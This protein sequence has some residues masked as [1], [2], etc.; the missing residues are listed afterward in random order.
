MISVLRFALVCTACVLFC[1]GAQ[2]QITA[3]DVWADWKAYVTSFGYSVSGQETPTSGGLTVTGVSMASTGDASL[4]AA[5]VFMDQI[6]LTNNADGSVSIDLPAVMPIEMTAPN[7]VGGSTRISMDY[8]H[9][10]I[11]ILAAGTPE[12]LNYNYSAA[13]VTLVSTGY[14]VDGQLLSADTNRILIEFGPLTGMTSMTLDSQRRYDQTVQVDSIR[15]DLRAEDVSSGASSAIT[16]QTQSVTF[17]GASTVPLRPIDPSDMDAMFAAGFSADGTFA[18]SANALDVT[19][20]G[21]SGASQG[22]VLSGEGTLGVS[23]GQD[24]LTY[25]AV[26]NDV[27]VELNSDQ[28]PVPLSLGVAESRFN[29]ATP[30]GPSD[31]ADDFALGFRLDGFSISDAIWNMI[32]PSGQVPR[33]P[34]LLALDLTGKARLL[35]DLFDPA[36][37]TLADEAIGVPAELERLDVNDLQFSAGGAKLT[38]SGGFDFETPD[39]G[40]PMPKGAIDLKLTGA[41]ALI[42]KLVESGLLPQDQAVGARLMMGLLAVPGQ[43]PDTLTSRIEI[44]DEGHVLANGQRIR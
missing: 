32:D 38:G 42:D 13:S 19:A 11:E 29:L 40:L 12:N 9:N 41:N 43:G 27:K 39:G 23:M 18:Y 15:Y 31:M 17:E 6:V 33:D 20:K 34:A 35:F 7:E 44:N 36:S 2:A 25:D 1:S 8:R 26:Q 24:G 16:G 37:A 4:G 14:E 21:S 28:F 10:A 30:V 5:T 3:E 22:T